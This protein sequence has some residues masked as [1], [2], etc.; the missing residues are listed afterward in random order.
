MGYGKMNK[1][2]CSYFYLSKAKKITVNDKSAGY[3]CMYYLI[4]LQ[5]L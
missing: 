4:K 3:H 1:D 5:E 2:W